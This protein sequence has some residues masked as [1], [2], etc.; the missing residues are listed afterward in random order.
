MSWADATRASR[1]GA[2]ACRPPLVARPWPWRAWVRPPG[3]SAHQPLQH[4]LSARRPAY[5]TRYGPALDAGVRRLRRQDPPVQLQNGATANTETPRRDTR[6]A[7]GCACRPGAR[8]RASTARRAARRSGN[9]ARR[10]RRRRVTARRHPFF[11]PAQSHGSKPGSQVQPCASSPVR[12]ARSPGIQGARTAARRR[13][14]S[15]TEAWREGQHAQTP[16]LTNT[17]RR[18]AH[19]HGSS[20]TRSDVAAS[21]E[22]PRR[23]KEKG[24]VVL[25]RG[26]RCSRGRPAGDVASVFR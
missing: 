22:R 11:P 6:S 15:C 7:L 25:T 10:R 5:I 13:S 3:S 26:R 20:T 8:A 14:R 16:A 12:P 2:P 1:R 17:A 23:G 4:W 19:M 9:R 21:Q 24:A 18:P